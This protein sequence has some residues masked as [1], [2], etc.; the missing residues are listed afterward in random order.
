[1]IQSLCLKLRQIDNQRRLQRTILVILDGGIHEID[2]VTLANA[3]R[4]VMVAARPYA[5]TCLRG[6]GPHMTIG[7]LVRH[8]HIGAHAA[9]G[10]LGCLRLP[11]AIV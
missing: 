8:D 9:V 7:A 11:S 5:R 10:N 3:V 2:P 6:D 1:M 4:V